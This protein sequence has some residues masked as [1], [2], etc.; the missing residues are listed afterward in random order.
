MYKQGLLLFVY[1]T[2][3]HA[4]L[5]FLKQKA[6]FLLTQKYITHSYD[7]ISIKFVRIITRIASIW[8]PTQSNTFDK[9]QNPESDPIRALEKAKIRSDP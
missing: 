2:A 9:N 6:V 7:E 4:T 5:R 1:I 8:N 3:S